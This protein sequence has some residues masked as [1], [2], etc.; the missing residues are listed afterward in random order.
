MTHAGI[1]VR[2]MWAD[3]ANRAKSGGM[4]VRGRDT[5]SAQEIIKSL[6]LQEAGC[7]SIVLECIPQEIAQIIT[8]V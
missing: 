2:G 6:A 5:A 4:K 7:F 1:A 8:G 3:A